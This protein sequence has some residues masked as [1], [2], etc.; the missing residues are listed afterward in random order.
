MVKT[1]KDYKIRAVNKGVTK[2]GKPYTIIKITDS[3]KDK[4]GNW[5][6]STFAIFALDDI[7][8]I[9]GGTVSI[10]GITGVDYKT[11]E[12]NGKTYS[13][14]TLYANSVMVMNPINSEF[15][16]VDPFGNEEMPF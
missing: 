4:D 1:N 7:C 14:C 9:E 2:N 6:S 13:D 3:T 10:D 8:A 16:S 5:T 11:R 15:A 12:W